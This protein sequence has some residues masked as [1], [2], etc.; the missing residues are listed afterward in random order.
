MAYYLSTNNQYQRQE[1][2]SSGL[3]PVSFSSPKELQ[4][5]AKR[6]WTPG[7]FEGGVR[8]NA[9]FKKSYFLYGDIDND[10][11]GDK[12]TMNEFMKGFAEYEFYIITSRSHQKSKKDV[13]PA[14]RFHVLFPLI[15]PI[16]DPAIIKAKLVQMIK[17]YPFFD[18]SCNDPARFFFGFDGNEVIHNA[19][20]NF[21]IEIV[22]EKAEEDVMALFSGP[23]G[24]ENLPPEVKP[25]YEMRDR[26]NDVMALLRQAAGYGTFKDY[27]E[28]IK[29]GMAMKNDGFGLEEWLSLSDP[30]AQ[31]DGRSKWETF[32]SRLTGGTLIHYCR[33]VDPKFMTK[34][35]LTPEKKMEKILAKRDAGVTEI[36][37]PFENSQFGNVDRVVYYKGN[38]IRYVSD[39]SFWIRWT[40]KVW[41]KSSKGHV[42]EMIGDVIANISHNESKFYEIPDTQDKQV[43]KDAEKRRD[44]FLAFVKASKTQ[45]QIEAVGKILAVQNKHDIP[46]VE[47]DLDKDPMLFNCANGMLDLETGRL[48]VHQRNYLASKISNVEFQPGKKC[49]KFLAFLDKVLLGKKDTINWIQQYAGYCLTG[50]SPNRVVAVFWGDGI[51]GKSTLVN[52]ISHIVGEYAI[53]AR[54][55]TFIESGNVDKVGQDIVKF[56]G[57]RLIT[58]QESSDGQKLNEQRIKDMTGSDVIVGRYLYSREDIS[59]VN[60]GKLIFSTNHKPRISGNDRGI[61]SRLKLVHFGYIFNREEIIDKYHEVILADEAS[62][63]LNWMLEGCQNLSKGGWKMP[64][65][66]EIDD[67]TQEYKDEE[68]KIGQ[69]LSECC[70]MDKR[71]SVNSNELYKKF[72]TFCEENGIRGVV[73][74]TRFNRDLFSREGIE[75]KRGSNGSSKW[76]ASGIRFKESADI[77][78]EMSKNVL[79]DAKA[80]GLTVEDIGLF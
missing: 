14:D 18:K 33:M 46:I 31:K 63:I 36:D 4:E 10:D 26:H 77:A 50:K 21:D 69:F 34:G 56:R 62:G 16:T 9:N 45:G 74:S 65:A 54:T 12:I 40:G 58:A 29:L 43:I 39:S 49:P 3:S 15:N 32:N 66:K 55:E 52:I 1:L 75:K 48:E 37:R 5:I 35:S 19:G 57:S 22:E 41:E 8:K 11:R 44:S 30:D 78:K 73:T 23:T 76:A 47:T 28:W 17:V 13:G 61:W 42:P 7:L 59:F 72:Q 60:T 70:V 51:N 80:T 6:D 20:R 79:E 25:D 38:D 68:D 67:A 2:S 71:H 53:Q 24:F 64:Y 27:G